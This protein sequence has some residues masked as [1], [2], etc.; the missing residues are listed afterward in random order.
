MSNLHIKDLQPDPKNARKHNARNIGMIER[1]LN[2]VGAA[3]SIV[4]DEEN[5]ILAGN[6]TI[7]AAANAGIHN[8]QIVDADGETIIAVRRKGLTPEQKQR[9][10]LFDNRTT[11]TSEFDNEVLAA[12]LNENSGILDGMFDDTEIDALIDSLNPLPEP[13]NGGD[14]FD[15]TPDETQTRVQRGDIWLLGRHRLMCGDSTNAD[16]VARLMQG[17]RADMVFT[18][19]PYNVGFMSRKDKQHPLDYT[20]QPYKDD[21]TRPEWEQFVKAIFKRMD[22]RLKAGGCFYIWGADKSV[23]DYY[24][25]RPDHFLFH[26]NIIWDKEWPFLARRDFLSGHEPCVYGWKQGAEHYFKRQAQGE[27]YADIWKVKKINP[28]D[29]EHSAQKPVELVVR[30]LRSSSREDEVM[31]DLFGGSGTSLIGCEREGRQARLIEIDPAYCDL[32][33]RRFTAESGIEP[34]LISRLEH[35]EAIN[36]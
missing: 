32:I 21:R 3:R 5:N 28:N 34:E 22:E 17:E 7:E 14:E 13:G 23:V 20:S 16:D 6:G 30:A 36:Q 19:P 8:V 9:L 11:D 25:W 1:S 31:L 18:D 10:A 12:L 29:M 35:Q 15:T 26:Q 33:L 24:N 2:E 4:I 27:N